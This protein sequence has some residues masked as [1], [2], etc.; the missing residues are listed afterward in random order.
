MNIVK[1]KGRWY[2]NRC[3]A[4]ES[5]DPYVKKF[6][7]EHE[8]EC[9]KCPFSNG[10]MGE[11]LWGREEDSVGLDEAIAVTLYRNFERKYKAKARALA[12]KQLKAAEKAKKSV[13][14]KTGAK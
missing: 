11:R 6:C 9:Y 13:K 5:K 4:N 1:V 7:D 8:G 12:A 2:V 14:T 3:F 10:L